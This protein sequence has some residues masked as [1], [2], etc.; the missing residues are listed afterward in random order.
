MIS[1][2]NP[3]QPAHDPTSRS[4]PVN[5]TFDATAVSSY[6][7]LLHVEIVSVLAR[8][9]PVK[10]ERISSF[11][12][13]VC[14]LGSYV[15]VSDEALLTELNG[16]TYLGV[17]VNTR[18]GETMFIRERT[19][20]D[21]VLSSVFVDFVHDGYI[22]PVSTSQ[23]NIGRKTNPYMPK[24]PPLYSPLSPQPQ[25][26]PQNSVLSLPHNDTKHYAPSKPTTPPSHPHTP[27]D[28]PHS[29]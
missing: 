8:R 16:R 15:Q 4:F 20:H 22:Q 6:T 25:T 18:K 21:G 13:A 28:T 27:S 2:L 24:I 9:I 10:K 17:L 1:S 5:L 7:E 23:F 26:Q 14:D 12:L 19:M 29:S 3:G 11:S